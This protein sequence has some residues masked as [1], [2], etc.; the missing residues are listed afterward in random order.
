M[1][2]YHVLVLGCLTFAGLS[3]RADEP[4]AETA[5]QLRVTATLTYGQHGPPRPAKGVVCDIFYAHLKI[6]G[7][8]R[9]TEGKIDFSVRMKVLDKSGNV[10]FEVPWSRHNY[11]SAAPINHKSVFVRTAAGLDPEKVGTW[12]WQNEVEDHHSGKKAVVETPF[13][14][15]MP[16][17]V[18][19]FGL[20]YGRDEKCQGSS[21]ASIVVGEMLYVNVGVVNFGLKDG[22]ARIDA[23]VRVLDHTGQPTDWPEI[24]AKAERVVSQYDADPQLG[25][26][27]G[28]S[29]L[30]PGKFIVEVKLDDVF[31]GTST[32]EYLPLLVTETP[33]WTLDPTQIAKLKDQA[34]GKKNRGDA[35]P[36]M[37]RPS[38]DDSCVFRCARDYPG[39]RCPPAN[40]IC[41]RFRLRPRFA[42]AS[43]EDVTQQRRI[44]LIPRS[45]RRS[46]GVLE[47]RI[48]RL[49]AQ[50]DQRRA[51]RAA[52]FPFEHHARAPL[53]CRR[54]G[55][56]LARH[57]QKFHRRV[58]RLQR[59]QPAGQL[60]PLV[61]QVV[62]IH[63]ADD[64]QPVV[65]LDHVRIVATMDG[66]TRFGI[67]DHEIHAVILAGGKLLQ[68]DI[69][70]MARRVGTQ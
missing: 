58:E 9:N 62:Q 43:A 21:S 51:H 37:K 40:D 31:G 55:E 52:L 14:T 69:D 60:L 7:L 64:V 13:E 19:M 67:G 49:L 33:D 4:A 12:T 29:A 48:A 23:T 39:G 50:R 34:E 28:F 36:G 68:G 70:G 3:A 10:A 35:P 17:G 18:A 66:P 44:V 24:T 16:P 47:D 25:V 65:Q 6:D 57:R 41:L 54:T 20:H 27:A 63:V 59:E 1:N 38:P 46:V 42:E 45:V 30:R 61:P 53:G 22:N 15:V 2:C 56:R 11:A 32:T 8:Q 5:D 26:L